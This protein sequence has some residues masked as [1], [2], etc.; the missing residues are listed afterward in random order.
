MTLRIFRRK[1]LITNR[2]RGM[3]PLLRFW[4]GRDNDVINISSLN[5]L[6]HIKIRHTVSVSL[7]LVKTYINYMWYIR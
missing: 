6:R 3:H 2:F 7:D 5:V 4:L 1:L